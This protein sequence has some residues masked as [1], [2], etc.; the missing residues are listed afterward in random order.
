[1]RSLTV[2]QRDLIFDSIEKQLTHE[3]LAETKNRKPLRPNPIV[4]WE[5]R[6]GN[7]RVFYEIGNDEPN[8]VR[9]LAVGQKKGNKVFIGNKEINL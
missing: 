9:I 6:I 2:R 3:P 7:L 8:V 5:L 1:M 4:P